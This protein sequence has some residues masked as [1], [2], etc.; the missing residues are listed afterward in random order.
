MGDLKQILLV[1]FFHN[2]DSSI[3]KMNC[4]RLKKDNKYKNSGFI[5]KKE[6]QLLE[7]TKY[8]YKNDK[9]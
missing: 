2:S 6:P 5:V 8:P 3:L 9:I 4:S 1:K 7:N